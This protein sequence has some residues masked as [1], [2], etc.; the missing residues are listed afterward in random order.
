MEEDD[1][2]VASVTIPDRMVANYYANLLK[3]HFPFSII[4][5]ERHKIGLSNV[6]YIVKSKIKKSDDY[7][8]NYFG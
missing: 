8:Y 4:T 6:E 1:Y 7:F 2:T 5:V 3:E